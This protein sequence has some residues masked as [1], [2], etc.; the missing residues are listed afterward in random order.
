MLNGKKILI[1]ITGS[2]AAY[3]IPFLVRLLKKAGAEVQVILTPAARDFV[4]P[5]TLSTLSERPV[6]TDF[7][8]KQDGS[9]HSHVDLGLWADLFLVAPLSANTLAKMATGIADNLLLTTVLSARCP[10]LFAPAMDLDMYRHPATTANISKLKSFGYKLIEPA[11]GELASGLKGMGRLEEPERIFEII[12]EELTSGSVFRDKKVLVTAGPTYEPVDPVRFIGNFS[13]GRMGVEI[14]RAFAASG[15]EVNLVLGPSEIAVDDPAIH[16]SRV[17]TAEE[18]YNRCMELFPGS[19]IIV[20]AAAVADYTPVETAAQKI[21]KSKGKKQIDL[22]PTKDILAGMG[23]KKTPDQILVGFALETENEKN[24]ALKKLK[25]K[26][27]DL[28]VLNSMK[29]EGAGFGHATNKVTLISAKGTEKEF[30]LKSKREVA[31]DIL[32]EI[33]SLL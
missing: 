32:A 8:N 2:I 1:G 31:R 17:T 3:K 21:K 15:A 19:E 11:E 13:S 33:E 10:V 24:N 25:N 29:D 18:M 28:I 12:R 30:P 16:V 26:N 4:T 6:L 5:L 7:F 27:L 9:W 23:S 22:K 14:A 20:M